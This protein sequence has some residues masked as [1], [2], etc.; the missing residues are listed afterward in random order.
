MLFEGLELS[1]KEHDFGC[2]RLRSFSVGRKISAGKHNR[3]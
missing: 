1:F 2:Q 3:K